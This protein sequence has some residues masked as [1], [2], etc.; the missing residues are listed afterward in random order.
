MALSA[1]GERKLC[2]NDIEYI[3]LTDTNTALAWL[4]CGVAKM[5][6][7]RYVVAPNYVGRT[8]A[9]TVSLGHDYNTPK[10]TS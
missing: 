6:A 1:F 8:T 7:Q 5:K 2:F 4:R 9:H 10:R 3:D